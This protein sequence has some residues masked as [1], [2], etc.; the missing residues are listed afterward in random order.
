[1]KP[2]TLHGHISACLYYMQLLAVVYGS[3]EEEEK[4]KFKKLFK[5]KLLVLY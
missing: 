4:K 5:H 1:M 2:F 3:F